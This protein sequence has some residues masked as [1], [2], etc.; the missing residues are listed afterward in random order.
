MAKT[1][2]HAVLAVATAAGYS[3]SQTINLGSN[4]S[5]NV[6]K[7]SPNAVVRFSSL[8]PFNDGQAH[9]TLAHP[10]I[11]FRHH[12]S[13]QLFI[14]SRLFFTFQSNIHRAAIL[15]IILPVIFTSA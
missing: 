9:F 6:L 2:C 3:K 4:A 7:L 12:Q 1:L 8:I 15:R 11:L 10:S 5:I 14:L 13:S